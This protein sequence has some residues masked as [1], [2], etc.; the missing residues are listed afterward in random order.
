M[1][2]ADQLQSVGSEPPRKDGRPLLASAVEHALA[3]LSVVEQ[4][5]GATEVRRHHRSCGEELV[6][7][8]RMRAGATDLARASLVVNVRELASGVLGPQACAGPS[9]WRSH[10]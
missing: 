9:G 10:P 1:L 3:R 4:P 8:A 2:D 6:V 5:W 7:P